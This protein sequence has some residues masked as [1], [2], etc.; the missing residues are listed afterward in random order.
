MHIIKTKVSKIKDLS[1]TAREITFHLKEDFDFKAGQFINIFE[2]INKEKVRRAYSLSSD[3]KNKKEITISVRRKK[4][5]FLSKTFWDYD[6]LEK[7][8]QI[9]GPLG[10]NTSDKI[11]H[12]KVFIFGFGIGVS[13]IKSV[14]SDL[15]HRDDIKEIYLATGSFNEEEII[16]KDFFEKIKK[17]FSEKFIKTRYV[18]SNP[19]DKNYSY[20]GYI[21]KY[22]NDFDFNNSNIYICGQNIACE[23]LKKEIEEKK[24]KDF[25][26]TI[27]SF[28]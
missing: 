15:L 12:S 2:K 4:D 16:Y 22:I 7:E 17:E 11:T 27:E 3:P 5:G 19:M 10:K 21:Q 6:I 23:S 24:P 20:I 8:F 14:L 28:G 26:F 25:N 18:L 1:P 9:M 13:A